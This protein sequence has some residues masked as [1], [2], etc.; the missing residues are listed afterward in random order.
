MKK[1]AVLGLT[2]SIGLSVVEV[3]RKHPELFHINLA[4]SHN[5]LDMMLSLA[6]ELHIDK[7]VITGDN[8]KSAS[9]K[10]NEGIFYGWEE[11]LKILR[12]EEY[13][14]VVNAISGSAGLIYTY[15][16][17]RANHALALANKE[18]LVMAGHLF[19]EKIKQKLV[20]PI[21]SEHSALFQ[22]FQ[23]LKPEEIRKVIIT[24]SGGPFRELPLTDFPNITPEQALQHPTWSMGS[25]ITI[26]SATMFNKGL[27]VIE[28]HWLFQLP[29]EKIRAIIHPQSI[30]HSLIESID[31]SLLAQMS[32]PSMQLPI[33]YALSYPDH[34]ESDLV[35]TD[36]TDLPALSFSE[37]DPQRYPL[38]ELARKAGQEG[39]I[40]PTIINSANEAAIKLFLDKKIAYQDIH[41]IAEEN[42]NNRDNV[43]NPDLETILELNERVYKEVLTT[44][45]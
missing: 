26:D 18:S 11:A 36:L 41:R 33:L 7:I 45:G 29:Y 14:L 12:S 21:D 19:A 16:T 32:K 38:Y 28:A 2:G 23:G 44:Y 22:L 13:D 42:L 35:K 37:I 5:N 39:G 6:E 30:I 15:H 17:L 10:Q 27:E 34:L 40:M 4:T 25:K 24:A 1:I 9:I 3:V 20:I 43:V 8:F 31:G